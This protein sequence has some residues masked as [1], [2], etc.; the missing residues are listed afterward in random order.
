[1]LPLAAEIL[2]TASIDLSFSFPKNGHH[3]FVL[4]ILKRLIVGAPPPKI[5]NEQYLECLA[6]FGMRANSRCR[7]PNTKR[8]C[9]HIKQ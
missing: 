6:P 7:T 9:Y 1:M 2:R 3:P 8:R 5:F 4:L